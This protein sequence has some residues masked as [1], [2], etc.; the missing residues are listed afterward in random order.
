MLKKYKMDEYPRY[1]NWVKY[2]FMQA[3]GLAISIIVFWL[4][5]YM[6]WGRHQDLVDNQMIGL[7][8][9]LP[10][11]TA[12]VGATFSNYAHFRKK[13]IPRVTNRTSIAMGSIAVPDHWSL[14]INGACFVM[15]D[16]DGKA[17]VYGALGCKKEDEMTWSLEPVILHNKTIVS[18][19]GSIMPAD[20]NPS[21]KENIIVD[22]KECK[23]V[24]VGRG[25]GEITLSLYFLD[26]VYADADMIA[27]I[28]ES[29]EAS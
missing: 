15:K 17:R 22:G 16:P 26:T 9:I 7:C 10:I 14:E 29:F 28:S 18:P 13:T 3:C 25:Y 8:M 12:L 20:S 11:A 5:Y 6:F 19:K 23:G 1:Q 21:S 4:A 27:V 2:R 24:A